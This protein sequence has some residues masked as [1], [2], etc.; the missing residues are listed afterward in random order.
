[1]MCYNQK[2][3]LE[4]VGILSPSESDLYHSTFKGGMGFS[5]IIDIMAAK[6]H[7]KQYY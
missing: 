3:N 1:M 6:A 4:T 5:V 2:V 7:I